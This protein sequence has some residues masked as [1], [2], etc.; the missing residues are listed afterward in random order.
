VIKLHLKDQ[1][2]SKIMFDISLVAQ[3]NDLNVF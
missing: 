2:K 3:M 1:M